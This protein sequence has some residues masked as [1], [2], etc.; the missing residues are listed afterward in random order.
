MQNIQIVKLAEMA[1]CDIGMLTTVLVGNSSTFAREGLMVTPRGYA[2]KYDALTGETLA[3]ECAGRSLSM[4]LEGWKA[5]VRRHL[6]ETSAAS[7]P[8]AARYFGRPLEEIL[9]A[10]AEAGP[11]DKAG[12]FEARAVLPDQLHN[13]LAASQNW[14]ALRA[15]VRSEGGVVAELF[16]QGAD[17]R[18]QGERISIVNAHFHLHLDWR[19]AHQAWFVSRS[20]QAH[21][22]QILDRQGTPL[23][24]LWLSAQAGAFDADA[25]SQYHNDRVRIA[26]PSPQDIS[27]D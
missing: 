21:G 25:L 10:V 19:Q 8:D 5:C 27:N 1:D 22:I 2:N 23:L 17:L 4:G 18:L 16:I 6:R 26:C 3:G 7:L 14:G 13:V 12:E 11:N 15:V 9:E 20:D 24:N